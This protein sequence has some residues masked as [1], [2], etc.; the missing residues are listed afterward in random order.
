MKKAAIAIDRYKLPAFKRV[1]DDGGL[2][3]TEQ[4]GIAYAENDKAA[5]MSGRYDKA[6][7]I[8]AL[9]RFEHDHL[10]CIAEL[11]A[12][13]EVLRAALRDCRAAVSHGSDDPRR[14]VRDI[15]DL[16]IEERDRCQAALK[17][18]TP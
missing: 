4:G 10:A 14:K 18:A 7:I 16:V 5:W 2:K 9:A 13:R 1:L 15:V 3:Y 8:Q 11:E 17:G 12:E 6:D